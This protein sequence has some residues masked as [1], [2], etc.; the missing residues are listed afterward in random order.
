MSETTLT[1]FT[2]ETETREADRRAA[3]GTSFY[4]LFSATLCAS[5]HNLLQNKHDS[6]SFNFATSALSLPN[7]SVG[8][9]QLLLAISYL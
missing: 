1:S 3:G 4:M 9:I 7:V 8:V 6:G 2:A 5:G